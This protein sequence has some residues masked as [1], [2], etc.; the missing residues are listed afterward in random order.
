MFLSTIQLM[1]FNTDYDKAPYAKNTAE[2][3]ERWRKQIKLSA[4]FLDGAF[5]SS[6]KQNKGLEGQSGKDTLDALKSAN[7]LMA[8]NGEK[9]KR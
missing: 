8:D 7:E 6:K 3:T 9:S 4:L 2:L 5:E 1:S